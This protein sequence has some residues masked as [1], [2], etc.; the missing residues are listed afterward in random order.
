MATAQISASTDASREWEDYCE[1]GCAVTP[2]NL[3]AEGTLE[4]LPVD[5]PEPVVD[6]RPSGRGLL[7]SLVL[8]AF[9]WYGI[10]HIVKAAVNLW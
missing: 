8:G 1:L 5:D 6:W 9:A 7:I 2:I 10:Y 4:N 3:H